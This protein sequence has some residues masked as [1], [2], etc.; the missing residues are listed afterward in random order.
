MLW[1]SWIWL[2]DSRVCEQVEKKNGKAMQSTWDDSVVERFDYELSNFITFTASLVS[3]N[4][5]CENIS[6]ILNY[7]N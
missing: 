1:I 4:S 5:F 6:K 3:T 2:H 7:E